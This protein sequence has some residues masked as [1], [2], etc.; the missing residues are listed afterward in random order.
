M[1]SFL[2]TLSL[3][4]CP[5]TEAGQNQKRV[6]GRPPALCGPVVRGP[7]PPVAFVRGPRLWAG[8]PCLRG[9]TQ[10]EGQL[11]PTLIQ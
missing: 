5:R 4:L 11:E 7:G 8:G 3:T 2:V 1:E 6:Q 10:K 9:L